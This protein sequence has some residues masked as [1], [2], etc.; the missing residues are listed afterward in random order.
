[1]G[2]CLEEIT[3]NFQNPCPEPVEGV[4][5]LVEGVPELVEGVPEP[6][7]GVPEPVE[8]SISNFQIILNFLL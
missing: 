4:P 7:E 2:V 8:G 3:N 6:V 5:E 1:M